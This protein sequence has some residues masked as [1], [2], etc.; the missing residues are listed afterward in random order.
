M[1]IPTS[2]NFSGGPGALPLEVLEEASEA[3]LQAPGTNQSILGISHRSDYFKAILKESEEIFRSL[4]NIPS[5]YQVLQLQGGSTLQ[6]SMIPMLLLRGKGKTAEYLKTGYWST[7]SIPDARLEGPVRVIYD[8]EGSGYTRLPD[9][10]ELSYD[11]QAAYFHYVSNETVEGLQFH[12]LPGI[13]GVPRVCDMASDFLSY[14]F[15]IKDFSLVYAHAQKNLGPAGLTLVILK[16]DLLKDSPDSLPSMLDY[17]NHVNMQSIYNTPP[18]FAIYVTLLVVRWLRDCIGGLAKMA[19]LN[20]KKA[21]SLYD[22]LDR[23]PDFFRVHAA[24]KDR[25]WM[26]V[27]FRL[28]SPELDKTFLEESSRAGFYGLEGHR[29]MGGLRASLYNSVTEEDVNRLL[30]FL[31]GFRTRHSK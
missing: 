11:P 8:G 7:K 3:I 28:P 19:A 29:S 16:D 2:L 18:V 27:A 31:D 13:K 23:H 24:K 25:S 14:P 5:G 12:Y 17:N 22:F 6:F 15:D 20:E 9:A 21:N 1:T 4:L 30:E 10:K 26:N